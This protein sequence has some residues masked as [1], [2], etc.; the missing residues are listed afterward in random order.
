[1]NG[2]P[3]PGVF[4]FSISQATNLELLNF[5]KKG[6]AAS[7]CMKGRPCSMLFR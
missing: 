2:M 1:M 3:W 7:I 5:V 6:N 4:D